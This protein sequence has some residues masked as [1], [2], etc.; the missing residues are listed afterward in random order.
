[1]DHLSPA[2]LKRPALFCMGR[3]AGVAARWTFAGPDGILIGANSEV[4]VRGWRNN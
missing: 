2:R 1:L 4:S 3:G